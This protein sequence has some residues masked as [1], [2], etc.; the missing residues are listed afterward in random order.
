ME[1]GKVKQIQE[2]LREDST[3]YV[4][5]LLSTMEENPGLTLIQATKIA[6]EQGTEDQCVNFDA[7]AELIRQNASALGVKLD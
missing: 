3:V 6:K 7:A 4:L 1:A 5:G 2:I